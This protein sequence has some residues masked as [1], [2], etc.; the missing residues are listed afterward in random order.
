MKRHHQRQAQQLL[1]LSL[2]G[3]LALLA[4]CGG[5]G[6][7]GEAPA[8]VQSTTPVDKTIREVADPNEPYMVAASGWSTSLDGKN[9]T[10]NVID[11]PLQTTVSSIDLG[12]TAGAQQW[13]VADKVTQSGTTITRAPTSLFFIK[14]HQLFRAGL[15]RADNPKVPVQLSNATT[16]CTIQSTYPL[17]YGTASA[18]V[19]VTSS[20]GT[21]PCGS[22][23]DKTQVITTEMTSTE[24]PITPPIQAF[25]RLQGLYDASG[26]LKGVLVEKANS[27][28][29]EAQL[30]L[31]SN[32]LKTEITPKV[33]LARDKADYSTYPLKKGNSAYG[34]QWITN[35]P[36]SNLG[37]YIR[38]KVTVSPTLEHNYLFKTEWTADKGLT[39]SYI[40]Y[41]LDDTAVT[42]MGVTDSKH[43][44]FV[45]GA[46]LVYGPFPSDGAPFQRFSLDLLSASTSSKLLDV[47]QSP[48]HV[49]ASVQSGGEVSTYGID[50]NN[51]AMG[52]LGGGRSTD[53]YRFLGMRG[54]IA[55]VQSRSYDS[56]LFRIAQTDMSLINFETF[57]SSTTTLSDVLIVGTLADR[58]TTL[59]SPDINGVIVCSPSALSAVPTCHRK[60]LKVFDLAKKAY[61]AEIGTIESLESRQVTITGGGSSSNSNYLSVTRNLTS[62]TNDVV[63]DVWAFHPLAPHSL[64]QVVAP[65]PAASAASAPAS[66]S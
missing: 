26:V 48:N 15:S 30:A 40:N 59:T 7:G 43:A 28:G 54:E 2:M 63:N 12:A 20:D 46:D 22:S 56:T 55:Y 32:D 44:Y 25:K 60:T 14:N 4:A 39:A 61:A 10:L 29:T 31:W 18:A 65:D 52:Y 38:V 66:S 49:V 57:T 35:M 27:D 53:G 51:G 16:L 36:N 23:K 8:V 34:A 33:A 47:Q 50:K 21:N 24:D 9:L 6:K 17:T 1:T 41:A 42:N 64:K 19:V 45:D 13:T 5:G 11:G 3:S 58:S 37:G 62:G